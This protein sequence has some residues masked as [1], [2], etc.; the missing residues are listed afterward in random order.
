MTVFIM[1]I[2]ILVAA[3]ILNAQ[4]VDAQPL[5]YGLEATIIGTPDDDLIDG[6]SDPDVIVG[7]AG[8]DEINGLGGDDVIC[9][10]EGRDLIRGG[11]GNDYLFGG[12]RAD[13]LRGNTGDDT[14][15]GG[16]END[17]LNGGT[18]NDDCLDGFGKNSFLSCEVESQ[19]PCDFFRVPMTADCWER[20]TGRPASFFDIF[21]KSCT[22][23]SCRLQMIGLDDVGDGIG[24]IINDDRYDGIQR[25][26]YISGLKSDK[27]SAPDVYEVYYGASLN[28]IEDCFADI[29]AYAAALNDSGIRVF[30]GPPYSCNFENP[31]PNDLCIGCWDY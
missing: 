13:I 16:R 12:R 3:I 7:L 4:K 24:A 27:C 2:I 19:C 11:D 21:C 5:C 10:G 17:V 15:R 22:I 8:N 9:G 23:K 30:G 29:E 20:K 18:G 25:S 26:C 28:R 6:T 1:L 14:L 31:S